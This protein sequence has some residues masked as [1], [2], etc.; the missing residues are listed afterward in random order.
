MGRCYEKLGK[1]E[2]A[3]EFYR[4]ALQLSPDYIEA[5]DALA[6]LGVAQ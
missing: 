3:V 5:K 4:T 1:K 6:K 2:D